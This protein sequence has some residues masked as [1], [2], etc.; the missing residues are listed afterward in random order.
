MA[1][2]LT[3]L[4]AMLIAC[5]YWIASPMLFMISEASKVIKQ[6]GLK[7]IMSN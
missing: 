4:W 2:T 7:Q 5:R 6:F 3:S 1:Q